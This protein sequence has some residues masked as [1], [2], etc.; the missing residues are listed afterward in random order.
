MYNDIFLTITDD[1]DIFRRDSYL[2]GNFFI[3]MQQ[4]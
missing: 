3:I 1:A 2:I 4:F